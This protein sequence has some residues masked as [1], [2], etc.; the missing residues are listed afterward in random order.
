MAFKL[1][2]SSQS[3]PLYV[4]IAEDLQYKILSGQWKDNEQIPPEMELCQLYDVSRITIRK[5]IDQLVNQKY[6]CRERGKGTFV[7]PESESQKDNS[8]LVQSFTSEM[9]ERGKAAI[10]HQADVALINADRKLSAFLHLD[11]G[12][13]IL[14]LKRVRG[15]EDNLFS[16][17]V[18]CIPYLSGFSLNSKDYYGS[19]YEYL[20]QFG[21]VM[22]SEK[23]YIEAIS[24]PSEVQKV[25]NI[26]C[27]TPV[28][29]RVR[30]TSC[31]EKNFFEYTECFYIGTEY[32][33]YIE[34]MRR[35]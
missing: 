11:I 34:M 21:I 15:T 7:R 30:F 23:E 20:K 25:L 33:Y 10:T 1:D 14:Q 2:K 26:S 22:N 17:F 32:R 4:Q 27:N 5:A 35:E 12:T 28:L 9:S 18:T 13:S 24:P 31:I 16:Y 19:L 3:F 8:T 6:L 29:K